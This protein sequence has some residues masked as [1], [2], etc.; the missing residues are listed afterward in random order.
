MTYYY[1]I[2]LYPHGI[3]MNRALFFIVAGNCAKFLFI[4]GPE[5]QKPV[6]ISKSAPW[7][8]QII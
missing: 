4:H 3:F 6:S 1:S 8:E 7:V 5:I 2:Y